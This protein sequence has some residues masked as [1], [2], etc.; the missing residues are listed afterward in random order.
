L[1]SKN[2][3]EKLVQIAGFILKI[4]HD[5]RSSECQIRTNFSEIKKDKCRITTPHPFY[6]ILLHFSYVASGVLISVKSNPI[7]CLDRPGRF[8]KFEAPTFQDSRHMKVV[9]LPALCTGRLY[10]QEIFLVLISDRG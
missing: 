9:R 1:H 8:Q 5:A 2:K 3:F 6:V 10:P 4:Y 7:T